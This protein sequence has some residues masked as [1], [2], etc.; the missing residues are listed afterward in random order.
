MPAEEGGGGDGGTGAK[1]NGP[2]EAETG[3]EEKGRARLVMVGSKVSPKHSR[4]SESS[5]VVSRSSSSV[6]RILF[7]AYRSVLIQSDAPQSVL[8]RLGDGVLLHRRFIAAASVNATRL[9]FTSTT[10]EG[11]RGFLH[12]APIQPSFHSMSH[13]RSPTSTATAYYRQLACLFAL[14]LPTGLT[15]AYGDR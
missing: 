11:G 15:Y 5:R 4:H 8:W 9:D 12:P 3:E 6:R 14:H 7:L 1:L 2:K 10:D 13:V